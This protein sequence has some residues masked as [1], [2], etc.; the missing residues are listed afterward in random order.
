MNKLLKYGSYGSFAGIVGILAKPILVP[1]F[2]STM[3]GISALTKGCYAIGAIT[4]LGISGA[5]VIA[6]V[7]IASVAICVDLDSINYKKLL[8]WEEDD[9][10]DESSKLINKLEKVRGEK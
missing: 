7:T 3:T 8:G 4:G 10:I 6:L 1:T 9:N 5:G 2:S